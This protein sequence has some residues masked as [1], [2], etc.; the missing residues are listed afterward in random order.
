MQ[1]RQNFA[2]IIFVCLQNTTKGDTLIK[3]CIPLQQYKVLILRRK[4]GA[5]LGQATVVQLQ[6]EQMDLLQNCFDGWSNALSPGW[7]DFVDSQ[8]TTKYPMLPPKR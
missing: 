8:G 2:P 6:T 3:E 4:K 5:N 1:L 7:T